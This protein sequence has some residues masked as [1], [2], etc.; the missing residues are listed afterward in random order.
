MA[1]GERHDIRKVQPRAARRINPGEKVPRDPDYNDAFYQ[2]HESRLLF[3]EVPD[4][5]DRDF[6]TE[7]AQVEI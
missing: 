4:Q 2:P 1:L 3:D 7:C 5:L 6:V